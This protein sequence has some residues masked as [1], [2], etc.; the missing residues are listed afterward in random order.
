MQNSNL[1]YFLDRLNKL[2]L[3]AD[4]FDFDKELVYFNDVEDLVKEIFSG[5]S[6]K[7]V[8][9]LNNAMTEYT[10]TLSELENLL[11]EVKKL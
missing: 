10:K 7:L 5:E 4:Q 3:K 1:E 11:D 8:D 2:K 6:F 9:N